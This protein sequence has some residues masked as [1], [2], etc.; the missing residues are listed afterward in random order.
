MQP[1]E[2]ELGRII[3][4]F[5]VVGEVRV[6]LHNPESTLL[7]RGR[8]VI[9]VAPDGSRRLSHLKTRD[10]AGK[11]VIGLLAE[12]ND[13][14]V[15][16]TLEGTVVAV[17]LSVLPKPEKGA[18]YVRDLIG[19]EVLVGDRPVGRVLEAHSTDGGDLLEVSV[20]QATVF[21]P[22]HHEVVIGI[23]VAERRVRLAE[24]AWEDDE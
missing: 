14:E 2:V 13:R 15:A 3:G 19:A 17:P 12:C 6:H 16:R 9:L 21:V 8:D 20:G 10:G 4:I 5:G 22:L 7:S 23:D 11:R 24:G 18:Y 1:D